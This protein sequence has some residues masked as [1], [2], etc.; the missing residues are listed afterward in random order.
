ML[1]NSGDSYK[2]AAWSEDSYD[3]TKLTLFTSEGVEVLQEAVEPDN[4][5]MYDFN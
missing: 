3:F 1:V 4:S 2:I 5:N